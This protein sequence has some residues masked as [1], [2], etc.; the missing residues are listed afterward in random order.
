MAQFLKTDLG[1]QSGK[2]L[3]TIAD[4]RLKDFKVL[5]KAKQFHSAVYM[6]GYVVESYLK[7][8]ICKSLKLQFLPSVFEYHHLSS[9]LLYSGFHDELNADVNVYA[10]FV[11]LDT[12]WK[13][14]MRYNDPSSKFINN[15]TCIDVDKYLNDPKVGLVPWFR[16]RL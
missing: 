1:V 7:C 8:G 3:R 9:L 11:R 2:A 15:Q 4:S 13:V 6:S 10:S 16:S 12:V 5:W 14:E